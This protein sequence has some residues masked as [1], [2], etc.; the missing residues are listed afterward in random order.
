M[1]G[2]YHYCYCI[3]SREAEYLVVTAGRRDMRPVTAPTTLAQA[4]LHCCRTVPASRRQYW[5][6]VPYGASGIAC[7]VIA[8]WR[9]SAIS[10]LLQRRRGCVR[11]PFARRCRCRCG[12]RLRAIRTLGPRT[13]SLSLSSLSSR[14]H[15]AQHAGWPCCRTWLGIRDGIRPPPA[16]TPSYITAQHSTRQHYCMCLLQAARASPTSWPARPEQK[17]ACG[18]RCRGASGA[19]T[20]THRFAKST[21]SQTAEPTRAT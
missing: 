14:A 15:A 6:T 8:V 12:G 20:T 7:H 1:H 16:P 18:E 9:A 10:C 3:D 21:G 13:L 17:D 4:T 19:P 2:R 11:V 5:Y